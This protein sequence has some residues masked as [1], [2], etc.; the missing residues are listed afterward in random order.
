MWK[1]SKQ[2]PRL[3]KLNLG[4]KSFFYPTVVI[5]LGEK[6][7]TCHGQVKINNRNIIMLTPHGN[8]SKRTICTE[9][10]SDSL[11]LSDLNSALGC[12]ECQGVAT[13][14]IFWID[15]VVNSDVRCICR[16]SIWHDLGPFRP[17]MFV[18]RECVWNLKFLELGVQ[19]ERFARKFAAYFFLA[20]E[21][22]TGFETFCLIQW[23][24][25]ESPEPLGQNEHPWSPWRYCFQLLS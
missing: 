25:S 24:Q 20:V 5:F 18:V 9:D 1:M 3:M 8:T 2:A 14:S 16:L 12:R 21:F 13:V 15:E 10:K 7:E 19:D 11:D 17:A 23:D 6:G 4:R 22:F